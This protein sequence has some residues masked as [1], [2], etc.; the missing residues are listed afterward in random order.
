VSDQHAGDTTPAAPATVEPSAH[1]PAWHPDPQGRHQLRWWD[2]QQWTDHV[3]SNGVS[4]TDPVSGAAAVQ[5][6]QQTAQQVQHQVAAQAG[7]TAAASGGGGSLLDLPVLVVNQKW[8]IIEINNEY[9][10]YDQHGTQVGG[11]RQVG[12]S[13]VKKA[14]RLVSSLDQYMTHT[15][16]VVD[17]AGHVLLVITRPAKL[18]KSRLQIADGAG[19]PIGEVVQQN[20]IGKIR[21]SFEVGGQTIGSIHAENWRAWNFAVRD[22]AG[23]E[24]ARI[25]KTW[26]GLAKTMFTSA[27]N[28]VVQVHRPLDDP[29]RQ[30]VVASA[31]CVDTALKQDSRGFN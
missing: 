19:R 12:Q 1:P 9:A 16:Q 23:T 17:A 7:I 2:G 31:L 10:V 15:L 18:V 24:I 26:E 8:K 27:D 22:A 3:S 20:A 28:Y 25:T 6:G 30:L 29:L 14:I 5:I 21:F 13:A 4:S 11:V